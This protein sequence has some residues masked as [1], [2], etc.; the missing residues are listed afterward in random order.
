M[1]P[2]GSVIAAGVAGWILAVVVAGCVQVPEPQRPL[3]VAVKYPPQQ[4]VEEGIPSVSVLHVPKV[5]GYVR[6]APA[7]RTINGQEYRGER[8]EVAQTLGANAPGEL[9]FEIV[10]RR[11]DKPERHIDVY[12]TSALRWQLVVLDL[13][14]GKVRDGV[15]GR[16]IL[17]PYVL[18]PG[19][20]NVKACK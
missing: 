4:D 17:W 2:S 9:L 7:Q 13:P 8:V 14:N 3:E 18:E 16:E 1:R 10:T 11:F 15:T 5:E 20:Y 12:V 6:Q 19:S